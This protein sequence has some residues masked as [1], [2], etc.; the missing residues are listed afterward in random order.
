MSFTTKVTEDGTIELLDDGEF[1]FALVE[2]DIDELVAALKRPK[3]KM[4]TKLILEIE[5]TDIS[6]QELVEFTNET[7]EVTDGSIPTA[8][9]MYWALVVSEGLEYNVTKA[10]IIQN[11]VAL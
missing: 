11:G 2:E 10:E 7:N 4:T 3:V 1:L 9:D 6:A 8:A 5:V